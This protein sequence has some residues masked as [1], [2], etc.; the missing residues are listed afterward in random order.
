MVKCMRS[1]D[2]NDYCVFYATRDFRQGSPCTCDGVGD[3]SN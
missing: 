1:D 3:S 2:V